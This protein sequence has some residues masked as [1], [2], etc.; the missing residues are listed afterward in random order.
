MNEWPDGRGDS[1]ED[2]YGRGSAQAQPEGARR[3]P[4]VRRPGPGLPQQPQRPP[5]PPAARPPAP[6]YGVP[7]QQSHGQDTYGGYDSGYNTGQ[8][9]G[10]PQRGPQRPGGPGE[11]G[12]PLRRVRH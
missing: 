6:A 1:R 10:T 4:H 12:W 8:V 5:Q 2:G 11:G 9:Y 3:M 7:Q